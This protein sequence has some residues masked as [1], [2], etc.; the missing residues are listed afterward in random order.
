M[1]KILVGKPKEK[2]PIGKPRNR[3]EDIIK[4]EL[5]ELDITVLMASIC[6]GIGIV[7]GSYEY[8]NEPS[9]DYLASQEGFYYMESVN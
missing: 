1:N 5:T 7:M 2:R 9:G 6:I 3:R 8:G 4:I